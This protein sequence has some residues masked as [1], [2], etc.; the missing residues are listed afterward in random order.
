MKKSAHLQETEASARTASFYPSADTV[1]G[2]ILGSLLRHQSLTQ[3]EAMIRFGSFRLAADVEVLRRR[4]WPI[5]TDIVMV[6]TSDAGRRSEVARYSLPTDSIEQAGKFAQ[7]YAET[8][9]LV[10]I[11]RRAA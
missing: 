9:R 10:E 4:G 8:C 7:D 11:E 2:R 1:R 5:H 3:K 6:T